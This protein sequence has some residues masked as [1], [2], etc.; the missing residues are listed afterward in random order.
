MVIWPVSLIF[1]SV[2]VRS[3]AATGSAKQRRR[4]EGGL[5]EQP[6]GK[7]PASGGTGGGARGI[8]GSP[9]A[10]RRQGACARCRRP[11]VAADRRVAGRR[12]APPACPAAPPIMKRC[13]EAPRPGL[14]PRLPHRGAAR[15]RA[16]GRRRAADGARGRRRGRGRASD[17]RR[18][19][20]PGAGAGG[21]RQQ[22]RRCL[23]RRALLR[24]GIPRRHRRLLAAIRRGCRP[25]PPRRCAAWRA[26]GGTTV[27]AIPPGWR[28][29]LVVDGLFGIGL[30]RPPAEPYAAQ[31][32]LRQ[33]RRGAGAGARPAQRPRR[34]HRPRARRGDPRRPRPR[35]SSP[36]SRACSPATA[37]DLR[38][39]RQR[40][41]AR[42][43]SPKR[44]S[45]R[46]AT[47]STG[48]R[49]APLAAAALRRQRRNVHKGTFGTLAILGGAPGH[50]RRGAAGRPRR[51]GRWSRQ[52]LGRLRSPTLGRRSTAAQ[53][54]LMLRAADDV[55][56]GRSRCARLRAGPGPGATPR[57]R[58]SRDAIARPVP[59]VARRRR[60]QSVA[61]D[62]ALRDGARGAYRADA[63]DAAPG[64]S[65]A[66]RSASP[67]RTSSATASPRHGAGAALQR[68]VVLKGAG[69][70]LAAPDGSFDVNA[71]GQPGARDRRH[72]RRARRLRR[73]VPGAG[74][75]TA[76]TALRIAVCLHGA[77]ADALRRGRASAR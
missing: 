5:G 60:A 8:V 23:R 52:G 53:P 45:P 33:R 36:G 29:E 44:S 9:G 65:R 37:P 39:R 16:R 68:H 49:R 47:A 30:A 17:D 13:P 41:C 59:L 75:S 18:R 14:C 56:A 26:A 51:A 11:S 24:G 73:R 70:V 28:G 64:R 10:S 42:A 76:R 38:R 71:H 72:R 31:I 2:P 3:C 43:R 1:L 15:G 32:A 12:P 22:R 77:A 57:E 25:T 46:R 48:R 50:G 55:L 66:A 67:P 4:A 20:R 74:R 61:A 21:S 6:H 27:A 7:P 19:R 35:R 69:S 40:A 34:R 58:C 62:T 63:A 54:E